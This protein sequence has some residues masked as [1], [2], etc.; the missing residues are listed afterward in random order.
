MPRMTLKILGR[1]YLF[2]VSEDDSAT[3]QAAADL[4]NSRAQRLHTADTTLTAE[5]LAVTAAL[6]IAFDSRTPRRKSRGRSLCRTNARTALAL[7]SRSEKSLTA[8]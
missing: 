3:L 2:N 5:R 4:I 1:D 7:R 6:E 8:F